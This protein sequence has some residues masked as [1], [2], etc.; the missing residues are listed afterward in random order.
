MNHALLV[1]YWYPPATGAAA[2]RLEAFARRLAAFGWRST[3]LAAGSPA[4]STAPVVRVRDPFGDAS[5]FADYDWSPEPSGSPRLQEPKGSH[6]PREGARA[7]APSVHRPRGGWLIPD[8][9]FRWRRAARRAA[10]S[11]A[12]DDRPDL[13]FVSF[14][15]ASAAALGVDLAQFFGVP[16]VVDFRDLWLGPGGYT[17]PTGLHRRVHERLERRVVAAASRLVA[18]SEKMA[19]HLAERH[20]LPRDRVVVIPN[21]YEDGAA[22][23]AQS[24]RDRSPAAAADASPTER[25]AAPN[26]PGGIVLAHVGTVIPRNRP[27][28]FLN[29]IAVAP[30]RDAWRRAG[31]RIRFVGNL[32][33]AVTHRPEFAGLIETTGLVS[34][35]ASRRAMQ[36]ADA[37][38]LLVG[39]Y[40]GRWGHNAKAFEYLAAG[41][42]I[43]C[44]EE[45]PG[46]NDRALLES[47][48]S[49]RCLFARLGDPQAIAAAID[50]LLRRAARGSERVHLAPRG[51]AAAAGSPPFQPV[52]LAELR[53][54][55]IY[56]RTA[57]TRRLAT[58]FDEVIGASGAGST[59]TPPAPP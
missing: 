53:G 22:T 44:L 52:P 28:L 1:G 45:T 5:Q 50:E 40:V 8:R 38:L 35:E 56:S 41:R 17:P 46:S 37:L 57:L 51:D 13:V 15:P 59:G 7:A 34:A 31:L 33:P 20:H 48:D 43:L 12:R 11:L 14:P 49:D 19:V 23:G 39:D 25:V 36:S 4:I 24:N 47:L 2:Q 26:A 29:S 18:V 16:L 42:P 55:S 9:F 54:L 3:V 32:A 10:R 6:S 21:G 27:D 30:Q 58:V